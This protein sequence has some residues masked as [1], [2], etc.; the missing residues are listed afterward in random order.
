MVLCFKDESTQ[1]QRFG[2]HEAEGAMFVLSS[3]VSALCLQELV[4]QRKLLECPLLSSLSALFC[5]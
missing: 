2:S 4:I 5:G 3:F 1:L